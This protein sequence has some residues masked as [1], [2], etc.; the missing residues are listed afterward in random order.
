[1]HQLEAHIDPENVASVRAILKVGVRRGE[2]RVK[3]HG[4]GRDMLVDGVVPE[5]KKRKLVCWYIDRPRNV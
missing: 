1:M 2:R 5:E 3:A 4:L